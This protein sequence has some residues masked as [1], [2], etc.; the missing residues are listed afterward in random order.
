MPDLATTPPASFGMPNPT[1]GVSVSPDQ[2]SSSISAQSQ[3]WHLYPVTND[4]T[5]GM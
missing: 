2:S 5:P 1:K 4:V 3:S